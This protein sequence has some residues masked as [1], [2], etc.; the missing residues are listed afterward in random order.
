M[1]VTA[2]LYEEIKTISKVVSNGCDLWQDLAQEVALD[3]LKTDLSKVT[4]LNGYIF[5]ITWYKFNSNN[6]KELL[7]KDNSFYGRYR[8]Y[9][10]INSKELDYKTQE[11][12]KVNRFE[13]LEEVIGRLEP[14]EQ[15]IINEY[16]RFNCNTTTFSNNCGISRRNLDLRI[17]SIIEK[18]KQLK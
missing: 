8:A 18:C 14:Q 5:M 15:L 7:S 13:R 3:V 10:I 1:E 9:G 2:E 4:N 6:G 12:I 17:K 16:L 11:Q